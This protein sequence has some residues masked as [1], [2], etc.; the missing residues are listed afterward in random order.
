MDNKKEN[1]NENK[2][3]TLK[4]FVEN[5]DYLIKDKE[6]YKQYDFIDMGLDAIT[7]VCDNGIVIKADDYSVDYLF[8]NEWIDLYRKK[9]KIAVVRLS[10]INFMF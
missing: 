8:G 2:G 9:E 6:Q 3:M 1:S 4:Q 5:W 7:I 10:L